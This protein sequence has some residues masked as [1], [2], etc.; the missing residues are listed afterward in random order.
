MAVAESNHVFNRLR[1]SAL[2]VDG[3]IADK[4]RSR[5]EITKDQSDTCGGKLGGRIPVDRGS[6]DGDAADVAFDKLAHH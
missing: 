2:I 1:N 6:H 5:S 4:R 3:D